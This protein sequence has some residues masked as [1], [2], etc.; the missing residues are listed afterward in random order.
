MDGGRHWMEGQL[1]AQEVLFF[2]E[3]LLTAKRWMSELL[4]IDP[5]FD[6]P[7]YVTFC[8]GHMVVGIHPSD[9]KGHSGPGGQVVYWRTADLSKAIDHFRSHGC[10]LYRGP[11]LGVDKVEVC[12]MQDPF[13]N[14]WGLM[15]I[16]L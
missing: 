3:D 9:Q 10:T 8:V 1:E 5:H 7:N 16:P 13:G 15:Q 2:V 14:L 4:G 11:I 12:Q 6:D